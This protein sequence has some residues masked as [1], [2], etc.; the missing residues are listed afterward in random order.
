MLRLLLVMNALILFS[1]FAEFFFYS[2]HVF[3]EN[4]TTEQVYEKQG[5]QIVQ[6][7]MEGING[8]VV[9]CLC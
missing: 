3:D 4:S 5:V 1:G 9:V 6:S 7:V 8:T 2:D